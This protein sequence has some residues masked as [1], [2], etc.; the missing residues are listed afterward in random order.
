MLYAALLFF[1][2]IIFWVGGSLLSSQNKSEISA[3][4]RKLALPLNPNIDVQV[5]SVIQNKRVYNDSSL[6]NFPIYMVI[7][8]DDGK[9]Q[10]VVPIEVGRAATNTS[11]AVPVPIV[12][13]SSADVTSP[14]TSTESTQ[15]QINEADTAIDPTPASTQSAETVAQ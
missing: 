8:S 3:E 11:A 7:R 12:A 2:L 6:S 13:S 1:V 4:L 9:T 15:T 5:L 10:Q 14:S